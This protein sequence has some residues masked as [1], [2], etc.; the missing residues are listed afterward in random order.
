MFYFVSA[1]YLIKLHC[2]PKK[3]SHFDFLNSSVTN[4]LILIIYGTLNPEG[5]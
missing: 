2:V 4:K 5:T 3:R 1:H